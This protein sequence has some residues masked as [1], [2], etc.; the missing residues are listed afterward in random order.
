MKAK[1]G[2]AMVVDAF[3]LVTLLLYRDANL[4]VPF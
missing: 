4:S 2:L 3:P 1:T